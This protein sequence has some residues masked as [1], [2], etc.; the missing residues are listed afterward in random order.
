MHILNILSSKEA[1]EKSIFFSL[2]FIHSLESQ[3]NNSE[4][5]MSLLEKEGREEEQYT[6]GIHLNMWSRTEKMYYQN[7][8]DIVIRRLLAF[9]ELHQRIA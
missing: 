5:I 2:V 7:T 9:R 1:W 8:S 4:S 6:Q 3:I